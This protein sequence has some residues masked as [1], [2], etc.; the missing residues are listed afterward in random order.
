[1]DSYEQLQKI[2]DTHP[3]TAPK[4]D[5][6]IEI[7]KTLFTPEEAGIALAMSFKARSVA[8]IAKDASL[9]T[10][11]ALKLLEGMADKAIIYAKRK[12]S[13]MQYG[14][15]PT[16]PGLFEFPFMKGGGSPMHEKLGGLWEKY[17]HEALG[18]SFS[19][20]PTPL[21]RVVAVEKA[22]SPKNRVHPFEEVKH[23]IENSSYIAL[24]QCACRTSVAKCDKPK[25][26]CLIFDG[27]AE[28][29]VERG[30]AW[31]ASREEAM[32]A[33]RRSDEAGLVHTSNNSQ[34]RATVIC[35]CC[36][37]CCTVLR[38]RTELNHPHA[39]EP[40]RFEARVDDG[41]CTGCAVCADERC[42]VK[43]IEMKNDVAVVDTAKCIGCGLCV[44]GCPAEALS[45]VERKEIP[46]TPQSVVEM[47][48]KVAQDKGRFDE[49][50]KIMQK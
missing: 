46:V 37:C 35:N 50:V 10:D 20:N 22:V 41:A 36:P 4:T 49:F 26:V 12:G 15:V 2:L 27:A 17:H 39:F 28:F 3:S 45:L 14:L 19:G 16:I 44:T 38:G 32:D 43:A 1:M 34:D 18:S 7:L 24:T 11:A 23:L 25:D 13:D 40:S 29:L 48:I 21:M 6:F 31:N 5:T 8:D 42:P 9:S 30:Y 47:G 33:L